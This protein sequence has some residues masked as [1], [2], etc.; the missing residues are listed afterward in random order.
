MSVRYFVF[1]AAESVPRCPL[2]VVRLMPDGTGETF[3]RDLVWERSDT[4]GDALPAGAWETGPEYA[5]A[6]L[7]DM[8]VE[9][10]AAKYARPHADGY[11]YHAL[12]RERADVLDLDACHGLV[13]RVPDEALHEL[14]PDGSWRPCGE[15]VPAF[16]AR[17]WAAPGPAAV[18]IDAGEAARLVARGVRAP[19]PF[20]WHVIWDENDAIPAGVVRM[21]ADG[22]EEVFTRDLVWERSDL[23]HHT[24][25]RVRPA[26]GQEAQRAIGE[27]VRL[28]NLCRRR[29]EGGP[30][31]Y[32]GIFR[33]ERDAVDPRDARQIIRQ[34]RENDQDPQ[35]N[36]WL[37][38]TWNFRTE[39]GWTP[40]EVLR[41]IDVGSINLEA[42]PITPAE[43]EKVLE[44]TREWQRAY[45]N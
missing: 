3:T 4:L 34:P 40:T 42:V 32:Y 45:G 29:D 44:W 10:R 39:D 6:F 20:E 33:D 24:P 41:Q 18:A 21:R 15:E 5:T 37:A 43:F 35:V 14:T 25:V 23:R 1:A 26:T 16:A 19:E 7:T 13:R 30:Y 36:R 38:E 17:R 9:M 22:I 12:F 8:V 27:T 2:K 28:M 11:V 31:Q